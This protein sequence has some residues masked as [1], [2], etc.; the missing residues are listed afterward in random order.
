MRL[1]KEH[2]VIEKLKNF[3]PIVI[4]QE[5]PEIIN[6]KEKF[7]NNRPI[8]VEVGSGKGQFI[9]EMAKKNPEINF[10]GIELRD[11]V[12]LKA[13]KKA[14]EYN[15]DNLKFLL[16]NAINLADIFEPKSINRLYLNF[17]DPWPK[18]RHYKRR[19]THRNFIEIYNVILESNSWVEFKTDNIILFQFTLNELA[20][21]KF[22]MKE[23]SLD[24]HNDSKFENNIM[25]EYEEKFSKKGNKIM[26]V[27]FQTC[28]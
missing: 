25:T 28:K 17:S 15:L 4:V 3:S 27:T 16:T 1:R 8:R 9:I 14:A 13:V 19:L 23:I 20:D 10:I 21:M 6:W 22:P 26:S 5:E 7:K 24:L 18:K 12:L 2:G 11:Q